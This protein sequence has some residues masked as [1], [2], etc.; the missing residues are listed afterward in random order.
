MYVVGKASGVDKHRGNRPTTRSTS[1]TAESAE[2]VVVLS[3]GVFAL[4]LFY[5]D[6]KRRFTFR[7]T[8]L[9]IFMAAV[10]T[11]TLALLVTAHRVVAGEIPLPLIRQLT[12]AAMMGLVAGAVALALA[13]QSIQSTIAGFLRLFFHLAKRLEEGGGI[14]KSPSSANS[15]Q[16]TDPENAG[17]QEGAR[18]RD[19]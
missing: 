11:I 13:C 19:W 12:L 16:G 8:R 6:T 1:L 14:K 17:P 2:V 3:L 5:R 4:W 10:F 18:G 7:W 9:A 15:Q